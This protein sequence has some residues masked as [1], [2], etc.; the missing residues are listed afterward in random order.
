MNTDGKRLLLNGLS[1]ILALHI[2]R[3]VYNEEMEWAEFEPDWTP[4]LVH[5]ITEDIELPVVEFNDPDADLYYAYCVQVHDTESNKFKASTLLDLAQVA[6]RY[7]QKAPNGTWEETTQVLKS[8][9]GQNKSTFVWRMVVVAQIIPHAVLHHYLPPSTFC[10][11]QG[12]R[13]RSAPRRLTSRRRGL[14]STSFGLL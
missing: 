13:L 14:N 3:K 1:T 9:Y 4:V 12:P 2:C 7:R 6:F 8:V 5:D 10:L 11:F